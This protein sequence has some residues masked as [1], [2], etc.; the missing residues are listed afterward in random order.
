MTAGKKIGRN[1][2]HLGLSAI[3]RLWGAENVGKKEGV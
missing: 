1:R 3:V 2:C